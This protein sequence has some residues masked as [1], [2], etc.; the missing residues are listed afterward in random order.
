MTELSGT[1]AKA[2]EKQKTSVTVKSPAQRM[3]DIVNNP[4]TV[5]ILENSLKENAGAYAAS[6]ID[7]YNSDKTL[8]ACEP[9][10]VMAECLKAVS[11]KLP[12]NRQLG[13]AYIIPYGG[14]PTFILGYRGLLQLCMRTGAYRHINAGPVYEGEL[15]MINKLTGD[16]DLDGQATSDKIV[17]Y[18]AY[19]E[20]LNGFSKAIYWTTEKVIN[21]AKKYSKN[22][23]G[24]IWKENFEEMAIKTL[25][26]YLL[27]HWG[28]MSVDMQTA[29]SAEN[30][31]AADSAI[32]AD[33]DGALVADPV[34]GEILPRS[35]VNGNL[36]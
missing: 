15:R 28:V 35:D 29:M 7:L 34:T 6:I 19:I 8:Q 26:R 4:A 9:S 27:S 2:A 30:T 14:T 10:R 11:L 21:H 33:T 3:Q 1:I 31:D 36:D 18:F 20:T 25:L 13:F 16:V 12:I 22:F 5:R 23:G 32:V 24:T 17:G